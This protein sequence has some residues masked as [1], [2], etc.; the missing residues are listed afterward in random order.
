MS[1]TATLISRMQTGEK[2][3]AL[4]EEIE[5]YLQNLKA[6][7]TEEMLSEQDE[8]ERTKLWHKVGGITLLM[9]AIQTDINTGKIAAK[10][11]HQAKKE[12]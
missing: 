1:E 10:Q 9:E 4:F 11:Y 6:Q 7:Y 12:K 8:I 5:G 3:Q 2:A